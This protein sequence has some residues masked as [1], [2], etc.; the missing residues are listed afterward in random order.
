VPLTNVT[1]ATPLLTG[2]GV[3]S[4]GDVVQPDI[5]NRMVLND[6][7]VRVNDVDISDLC[8]HV[9]FQ[10][11][12]DERDIT[13]YGSRNRVR[14]LGAIYRIEVQLDLILGT[15]EA[16]SLVPTSEILPT[17]QQLLT[18]AA[19]DV[20]TGIQF[21]QLFDSDLPTRVEISPRR[22]PVPPIDGNP[23]YEV[24]CRITK[25]TRLVGGVGEPASASLTL[26]GTAAL[27]VS[28]G[29]RAIVTP[30]PVSTV[31]IIVV[32]TAVEVSVAQGLARRIRVIQAVESEA[33]QTVA[34][35]GVAAV[36]SETE[37]SLSV[38]PRKTRGVTQVTET[39]A[40]QNITIRKT[41]ALVQVTDTEI[42][43]QFSVR[44]TLGRAITVETAQP[45]AKR[46]ARTVAQ[47]LD[48]EQ[49]TPLTRGALGSTLYPSNTLYPSDTLYPAF[50]LAPQRILIDPADNESETANPIVV[51]KSGAPRPRA[52]FPF[53]IT[54]AAPSP[55]ISPFDPVFA[56]SGGPGRNNQSAFQYAPLPT[57]VAIDATVNQAAFQTELNS[58]AQA[59]RTINS[60]DF[61]TRR[62]V[63][64]NAQP[65]EPVLLWR[66][67]WGGGFTGTNYPPFALNADQIC[68]AGFPLPANYAPLTTSDKGLALLQPDYQAPQW[69]TLP[70]PLVGRMFEGW[71]VEP[72]PAYNPAQPKVWPNYAWRC[73][74]PGRVGGLNIFPGHF[75]D[76]TTNSPQASWPYTGYDG[77][78]PA[79]PDSTFQQI[80]L[81]VSASGIALADS[82]ILV[83]DLN[84]NINGGQWG[85]G[86]CVGLNVPTVGGFRWP[87]QRSDATSAGT[88]PIY[89]GMRLCL[90]A[91]TVIPSNVHPVCRALIQNCI[92]SDDPTRP[93]YGLVVHEQTGNS[94]LF[95]AQPGAEAYWA[96]VTPDV[97]LNGFPWNQLQVI[98]AGDDTSP[99][100]LTAGPAVP[101]NTTPPI[102]AGPATQGQTIGLYRGVWSGGAPITYTFQW[103]RSANGTTWTDIAGATGQAYLIQ[104]SDVSNVL[105]GAVTATNSVGATT[106]FTAATSVIASGVAVFTRDSFTGTNGTTIVSRTGET[107]ATWTK[108]TASTAITDDTIQANRAMGPVQSGTNIYYSSAI[109]TSRDYDVTVLINELANNDSSHCSAAGRISTTTNSMYFLQYSS[110]GDTCSLNLIDNNVITPLAS[111]SLVPKVSVTLRMVGDQITGFV[112]NMQVLGPIT[113]TTLGSVGRAGFRHGG[114]NS[115]TAGIHIDNFEAVVNPVVPVTFMADTFAG[116]NGATVISRAGEIGATWTK[117]AAS[118]AITHDT[119]QSN[120]AMGPA[121]SG[122]NIYYANGLPP[123]PDYDVTISVVQLTDNNTSH[124]SA[125]GRMSTTQ[126]TNYFAQYAQSDHLF[127]LNLMN[128]NA[129]TTLASVSLTPQSTVTLR[130]VGDQISALADGVLVLGPVTNTAIAGAGLAGYRH[131]GLSTTTTAIHIDAIQASTVTQAGGTIPTALTSSLSIP[132]TSGVGNITVT[133][134]KPYQVGQFVNGDNFVLPDPTLGTVVVTAMTP[135]YTT[136]RHGYAV[137]P[138]ATAF[139]VSNSFDNRGPDD[140]A[141]VAPAALPLSLTPNQSLIKVASMTTQTSFSW[142]DN[143]AVV[144]V[145]AS[146]PPIGTMRPAA[147]GTDKHLISSSTVSGSLFPNLPA[148]VVPNRL[149][150][151]QCIARCQPFRNDYHPGPSWGYYRSSASAVPGGLTWGGDVLKSD[152][153]LLCSLCLD[154]LTATE[155]RDIAIRYAQHG[156][157]TWGVS[158]PATG[159]GAGFLRGGGANGAGHLL[160]LSFAAWLTTDPALQTFLDNANEPTWNPA[161]GAGIGAAEFLYWETASFYRSSVTS[162]ALWGK[163]WETNIGDG[164]AGYWSDL[165]VPAGVGGVNNATLRDPYERIDGG[166]VP[167]GSYQDTVSHQIMGLAALMDVMTGFQAA[168]PSLVQ[169]D[170]VLREYGHRW[171]LG[172]I[173]TAPDPV[174]PKTPTGAYGVNYGP[175]PQTGTGGP[176]YDGTG[177]NGYI[178][179][180]GRA[181]SLNN[182]GAH[183]GNRFSQLTDDF[184][185]SYSTASS[186]NNFPARPAS[187]FEDSIGINIHASATVASGSAYGNGLD[188]ANAMNY[189]GFKHFRDGYQAPALVSDA[190]GNVA[191]K[192]EDIATRT[193]ATICLML[194]ETGLVG[195]VDDQAHV[196]QSVGWIQ[197]YMPHVGI[198]EGENEADNGAIGGSGPVRAQQ[199]QQWLRA[200]W[201]GTLLGPSYINNSNYATNQAAY[202]DASNAHPYPPA[203]QALDTIARLDAQLVAVKRQAPGKPV[204]S[205][206]TGYSKNVCI[207]RTAIT[208]LEQARWTISEILLN[209]RQGAV[210]IYL[211][212][213]FNNDGCDWGFFEHTVAKNPKPQATLLRDWMTLMRDPGTSPTAASLGYSFTGTQDFVSMLWAK[214]DGSFWLTFWPTIERGT[215]NR[216][217]TMTPVRSAQFIQLYKPNLG[218]AVQQQFSNVAAGSTVTI[219]PIGDDP[220]LVKVIP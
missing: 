106:A 16:T 99:I 33:P 220:F 49:S 57:N 47:A 143:A 171:E 93:G 113:D 61:T 23:L 55:A 116:T 72:N 34:R 202:M 174:A 158:V 111:A 161:G 66:A 192:Q 167:G 109:P 188:I 38:V 147:F 119:I 98:Q 122:T 115:A 35:R 60:L 108:H 142:I 95:K 182:T 32:S 41:R 170:A 199:R 215:S 13:T 14:R 1:L 178:G 91:N 20:W 146:A 110:A 64:P 65:L 81:G 135:T 200:A 209:I 194:D 68:R 181:P 5:D 112:D 198:L 208:E 52:G 48:T 151:A 58:R 22:F 125:V 163:K 53:P 136:G 88:Y 173:R 2:L 51:A 102:T 177:V 67:D 79:N 150:Y 219:G 11:S 105:R 4:E 69:A 89:Y 83:E 216:T 165:N 8:T 19:G 205:T 94:V 62:I 214:S 25:W 152:I 71:I 45:V 86:H 27:G 168:W 164:E 207:G 206:E 96:G 104:A 82:E 9:S 127:S 133:F 196:N 24:P 193:G 117:L 73:G 12:T 90:P 118:T 137:N 114:L 155:K 121:Q 197:Q 54:P 162:Q 217:F 138:K 139:N 131:G 140:S 85:L 30:P 190:P 78:N 80:T 100:R 120:R 184:V 211:Y 77:T 123:S 203:A 153:E 213:L 43:T 201:P 10:S 31:K 149:T 191:L 141:F 15:D 154:H 159:G 180:S 103:Q 46:K 37:Q 176:G 144:T 132:S 195:Q 29:V 212:E 175:N 74:W 134:N 126:N 3:T 101:A 87:A 187:S 129:L 186:V 185:T 18:G 36:A 128:N 70:V 169:N 40:T 92:I 26:V 97:V 183:G 157:D 21:D 59:S 56:V 28:R 17:S 84:R 189:V 156:I 107:A 76:W 50:F 145:L 166:P 7:L 6:V 39:S 172:G 44:G 218:T 75:V 124:Y 42:G 148:A 204:Y 63:V 130:M 160:S 179:G 210:R